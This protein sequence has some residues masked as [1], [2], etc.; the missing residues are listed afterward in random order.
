MAT[1]YSD[2]TSSNS[3]HAIKG[4]FGLVVDT[5]VV[6]V[7]TALVNNDIIK[8]F[9][10][11]KGARVVT[12]MVQGVG[13]QSGTDSEF[14]LGDSGDQNRFMG[15]STNLRPAINSIYCS[16]LPVDKSASTSIFYTYTANTDIELKITTAGTGM[17]T[18]GTIV[19]SIMYFLE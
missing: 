9:T 15:A 3:S 14:E 17:T 10:V 6:S 8:L 11:P 18:G 5:C 12:V 2:R 4:G 16:C 7:G 13:V 19:S 1:Y